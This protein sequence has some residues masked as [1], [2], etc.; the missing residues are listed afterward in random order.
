MPRGGRRP[1]AGA[2]KHNLNAMKHGRYSRQ[3]RLIAK[4]LLQN[5][6]LRDAYKH[7]C[8]AVPRQAPS[9]GSLAPNASAPRHWLAIFANG[10]LTSYYLPQKN[11]KIQS[12]ILIILYPENGLPEET[13]KSRARENQFGPYLKTGLH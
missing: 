13:I 6:V 1:G 2:R 3:L 11:K 8:A 12:N 9:S 5:P 7:L 10:K 4:V